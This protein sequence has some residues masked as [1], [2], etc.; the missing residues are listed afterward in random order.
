MIFLAGCSRGIFVFL[1][2]QVAVRIQFFA[3]VGLRSPSPFWLK[4]KLFR[5]S[6]CSQKSLA[7]FPHFQNFKKEGKER[8]WSHSVV[9]D[10]LQPHGLQPTRLFCP[11]DF[12]GKST[13]VGCH[14]FFQGTF[15]TQGSNPGLPHC[16]QTLLLSE[17]PGKSQSF[18]CRLNLVF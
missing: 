10:S 4:T 9:S 5:T 8:K 6:R 13:G 3:F 15:L 14:F 12:P 1:L 18:N 17:P 11:W 16:R 7:L 2:I